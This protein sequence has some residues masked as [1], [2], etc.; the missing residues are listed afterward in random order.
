M[1]YKKG[2][3]FFEFENT[4]YEMNSNTLK[5][6]GH[7]IVKMW[8]IYGVK[9]HKIDIGRRLKKNHFMEHTNNIIKIPTQ[10]IADDQ[11]KHSL[12]FDGYSMIEQCSH[13]MAD[14]VSYFWKSI[15]SF[16]FWRAV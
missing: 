12:V 6:N 1:H 2:K 8:Y 10:L 13:S 4:T 15:V 16:L 14:K 7:H 5:L 9:F 3:T 11:L